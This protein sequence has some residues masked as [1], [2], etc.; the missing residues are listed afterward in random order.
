MRNESEIRNRI[1]ELFQ[2]EI[3]RRFQEAA[4][5]VPVRCRHNYR[6]PLDV[7]KQGVDGTP[8]LTYNRIGDTAKTI[9]LCLY[10][11][12]DPE[13]WGGDICEDVI[14]AERCPYFE[15][16]ELPEQIIEKFRRDMTSVDWIRQNLPD[17]YHLLWVLEHV[18]PPKSWWE[19][20]KYWL[21]GWR[22]D[23]VK[24]SAWRAGQQT[25]DIGRL[26][27]SDDS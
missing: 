22:Y 3:D 20:F 13:N 1:R 26:L 11:S 27:S 17:I 19:R 24:V 16:R 9:G 8:N 10:G 18:E 15:P 21:L 4:Q 2:R 23:S 6:H 14:D 12:D 7:Q 25:V 5:R